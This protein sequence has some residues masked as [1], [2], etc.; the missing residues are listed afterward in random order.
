MLK[1]PQN[2]KKIITA[3][4]ENGFEAYIVGGAVR[5]ALLGLT[6]QDYDITTS[7]PP[8]KITEL[9]E[10]TVPT[11][12][13]HGTVTVIIDNIPTEVTT[14]RIDGSYSDNRSPDTVTFTRSLQEDLARRDFTVNALAFNEKSGLADLYSGETDL[15]N[16]IIRTVG[17]PEIRFSE[18]A[19]RILRAVRFASTL[20]F[21]IEERTYNAALMLAENLQS[22]S[23]ERI[24]TELT[25]TIM[26]EN[27]EVLGDFINNGGLRALNIT[28]AADFE[29]LN[30]LSDNLPLRIFS[31]LK[32]TDADLDYLSVKLHFSNKLKVYLDKAFYIDKELKL[33]DKTHIK[34]IL[35]YTEAEVFWDYLEYKSAVLN[36]DIKEFKAILKEIKDNNEPYKISM[37]EISGNDLENLGFSGEEIGKKLRI[38]LKKCIEN[39]QLN[40]KK[41][42]IQII[43]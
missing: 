27:C 28:Y 43:K 17:E 18:D 9:F 14:Y 13:K 41:T 22:I 39:P 24:Y 2:I 33:T 20:D 16:K 5:D 8:E 40:N 23:G 37:L 29:L 42:L 26:G 21:K 1:I 31:F 6:P 12:I 7:C 19:L 11:G 36:E 30:R 25:K 35:G 38:L 15:R 34:H 10:K 4:E 3:L 32:L